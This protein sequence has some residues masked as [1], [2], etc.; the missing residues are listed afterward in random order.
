MALESIEVSEKEQNENTS[1]WSRLSLIHLSIIMLIVAAL[2]RVVD[3]FI[4]G[5]G[6]TWINI[7]PSK[8]F[9]LLIIIGIFWRFRNE[10][11]R[12][13]LGLTSTMLRPHLTMGLIIAVFLFFTVDVGGP[14]LYA[15]LFDPSYS[16]ALNV[17]FL[18]YIWYV[19]LFMVV[20][21]IFEETLF[22][23]LLQNA[24]KTCTTP[25]RA[26][27]LSAFFFGIWHVVWPLA[28]SIEGG[29][30]TEAIALV[31][32]TGIFGG[33][34]GVYYERFSSGKTL[35]GPI[36][37]HALLNFFNE[38]F[39]IGPDP[40]VEGPDFSFQSPMLMALT[41]LMYLGA[42]AVLLI[43]AWRFKI[44]QVQTVWLRLRSKLSSR[45][46]VWN[47]L[48]EF[49]SKAKDNSLNSG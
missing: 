2:W 39:K 25:N 18:D 34:F 17:L 16:L 31:V 30:A 28:S 29:N 4:L 33:L 9:P 15:S 14:V 35:S 41:L 12:P 37:A 1:L 38:C 49:K 11:A 36:L 13:I 8:L 42:F 19:L 23:G 7:L 21:A 27:I 48:W 20:N 24:F 40:S 22:R 46:K 5:L 44:E 47:N 10:E 32:M 3:V 6:D 45:F 43:I 26:I